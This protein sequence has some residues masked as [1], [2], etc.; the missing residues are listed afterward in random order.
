MNVEQEITENM[1]DAFINIASQIT[2]DSQRV[3]DLDFDDVVLYEF[4]KS[5]SGNQS[6]E[7]PPITEAQMLDLIS[8][9]SS[10][11]AIRCD[12]LSAK[13][14]KL[15]ASVLVH[16]LCRLMNLSISTGCFPST[17][18]TAQVTPLFKSGSRE[19]T[20]NYRPISVSPV[21]SKILERHVATSLCKH[22]HS[23]DLLCNLQSAFRPNHSTETAL[24]KL[25]DELLFNMD[26]DMVT[27]LA[28]VDFRKA[29]DVINHELLLKKLSIYG[30]N[31]LSLKWFG[32]YLTG[33][34]QYV[35]ING[36]CS[37]SKQLLQGMPQG[38]ILGP[39]LFLLFVNDMP[40]S[41]RDSTLDVYADDTTLSKCSSWESVLHLT[42]AQ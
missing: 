25:T 33:R 22:L 26:N 19:D 9:I 30:A 2:S 39:I 42:Q 38:S 16:P 18:K 34:K 13:V 17:W 7:I 15:A 14:L 8:K 28:F 29:F 31:D 1:N 37:T 41:I 23:Y 21:L 3:A 24:I 32:S 5:K 27:G 4:V 12:G 11:K 20:S 40:L 35:R 36:C 6:F 10:S